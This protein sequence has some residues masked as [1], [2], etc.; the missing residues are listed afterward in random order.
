MNI[1]YLEIKGFKSVADLQL[2]DI[3][4]FM[5]LAGA[6]GAGKSNVSDA[7]AFFGAVVQRGAVQA[8]KEFGGYQQ[9]HCYQSPKK[10][11][12]TMAFAIQIE[13]AGKLYD[14]RLQLRGI[15]QSPYLL[16]SLTVDG[17]SIIDR[18][19]S[20]PMVVTLGEAKE[21]WDFPEDMSA[22]MFQGKSPLYA[23]L[24]NI[25]VFR[26]DPAAAK[27]ANS[28]SMDASTLDCQGKNVA[29]LLSVLEKEDDFREQIMEWVELIV[30]G[31]ESINTEQQ[32]LDGTTVI[33]FKEEGTKARFPAGLISDGTIY[34]LAI[35][36]AVL[37]RSGESG[38]TIIEEP[39]RGIH[40]K[41]IGELVTLFRGYGSVEH[42]IMI[43]THS[44]SVV[45]N[46]ETDELWL[47]GKEKGKTRLKRASDS[48]VDKRKI[49]L[50]TAW[51]TN[52]FGG[53]LPW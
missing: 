28:A 43:T 21:L 45:R 8:I 40:P 51:L 24:T 14:Y 50:D 16:E 12:T 49:A 35:L 38:I 29:A 37:S 48:G 36:T 27:G 30:P 2:H 32:R 26:I 20:S 53:G 23:F 10:Q 6:N 3:S 4:P 1:Q 33:T 25:R 13:L 7:L 5:A 44:E 31:M 17:L 22:L 39:E 15:D 19:G 52:L 46:L 42:P 18:N 9:I 41:A 34:T 11:Q 47:V